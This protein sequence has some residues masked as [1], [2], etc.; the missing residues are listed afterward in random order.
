M[1][2]DGDFCR[3]KT[4]V[5]RDEGF[6]FPF[7]ILRIRKRSSICAMRHF[8]VRVIQCERPAPMLVVSRSRYATGVPV[9]RYRCSCRCFP[10]L[11]VI[12]RTQRRS[13]ICAIRHFEVK[14]IQCECPGSMHGHVIPLW[15]LACSLCDV[16]ILRNEGGPTYAAT[17]TL[18]ERRVIESAAKE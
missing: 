3:K 11:F 14:G 16:V 1:G 9:A 8:E 18:I 2:G 5:T 10:F 12:L 15:W 17:P 13:S 4:R 7:M 6:P